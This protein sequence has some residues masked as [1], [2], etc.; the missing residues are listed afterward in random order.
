MVP[1]V[2]MV[3]YGRSECLSHPLCE[4]LLQRKWNK[5]GLTLYG[6]TTLMYLIF[7]ICLTTIVVQYPLCPFNYYNNLQ[8]LNQIDFGVNKTFCNALQ[9]KNLYVTFDL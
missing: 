3:K 4:V 7:L 9:K 6:I 2:T 1:L 5:Y 8:E